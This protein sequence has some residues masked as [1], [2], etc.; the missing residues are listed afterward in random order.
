MPHTGTYLDPV[1]E[2]IMSAFDELH[3]QQSK[4][5]G[6]ASMKQNIRNGYRAGGRAPYGY[7]LKKEEFGK[8]RDG[9]IISK[10]K[11]EPDPEIAPIAN[12]LFERRARGETRM[13]ILDDFYSRGISSPSGRDKWSPASA[14]AIE[15]NV[16]VYLGHTVFNRHNEKIKE[17]GKSAGYLHGEK[18]RPRDEWIITENTHEPLITPEI[19]DKIRQMKE[20]GLRDAPSTAKRVYSLSGLMKCSEC[21]TNY[22]GDRGI[23]KCNSTTKPGD[24]CHNNDI[25]QRKVEDAVFSLIQHVLKIHNI[26][27]FIARV[28]SRFQSGKSEVQTL[29]ERLVKIDNQIRRMMKLYRMEVINDGDIEAELVPLQK[30]KK[31]IQESLENARPAQGALEVTDDAIIGVIEHFTEEV[32]HADPKI[33]KS[34]VRA[35]FQ[36]FRIFPKKGNPWERMLEIKGIYLPLTR[37]K[38]AS[39]RGFEPLSQA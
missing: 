16:A 35:L 15:D 34:A 1:F 23:Y 8:H 28:K 9:H 36:E 14:K 19:A 37:L 29:E 31:A 20:K 2:T 18:W 12:E 24:K 32:N 5:K 4:V 11:L 7:R 27:D 22:T 13:S 6:V 17:R 30:Q 33:R 25:S 3:S 21:G 10:S 39:P 38:L 26:K